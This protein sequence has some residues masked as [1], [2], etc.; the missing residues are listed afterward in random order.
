MMK[1]IFLILNKKKRA[2]ADAEKQSLIGTFVTVLNG[3]KKKPLLSKCVVIEGVGVNNPNE[4]T[5]KSKPE[6][7]IG[8]IGLDFNSLDEAPFPLAEVFI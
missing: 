3:N 4:V 6:E 8:L 7:E 1:T 2:D 5:A